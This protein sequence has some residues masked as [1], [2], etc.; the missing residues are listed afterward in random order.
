MHYA[1]D[2]YDNETGECYALYELEEKFRS[3]FQSYGEFSDYIDK[4]YEQK[5]R[6]IYSPYERCRAAVYATGNRWAIE[7]FNA[8]HN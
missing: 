4:R 8:T 7:N 3:Q 5:C 1:Y 2:Y 6:V